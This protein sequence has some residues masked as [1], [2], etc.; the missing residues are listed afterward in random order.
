MPGPRP[1]GEGRQ[2]LGT[3]RC[4]H[5]HRRGGALAADLCLRISEKQELQG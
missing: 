5:R 3:E 4:R 2:R 1:S